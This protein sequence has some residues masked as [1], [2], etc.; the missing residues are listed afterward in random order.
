MTLQYFI[1]FLVAVLLKSWASAYVA[2][3]KGSVGNEKY[4]VGAIVYRNA[5]T[6]ELTNIR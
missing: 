4:Q 5:S 3:A 6:Y 1:C 2:K